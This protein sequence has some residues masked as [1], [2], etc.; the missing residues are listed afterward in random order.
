MRHHHFFLGL[1]VTLL[2]A[3]AGGVTVRVNAISDAQLHAAGKHYLLVHATAQANK[4]DLFFREFSSYFVKALQ[5]KGYQRVADVQ[6]ADM[7]IDFSYGVSEGRT[8]INTYSFPIYEATGGETIT[9][10]ETKTDSSGK[11]TT[12]RR[13]VT[14]PPRYQIVGTQLESSTYTLYTHNAVLEARLPAPQGQVGK[15]LWKTVITAVVD[16]N[17]LRAIMP[18]LA[19]AA[20]PYLG[21]NSGAQKSINLK[22]DSPAVVEM[23]GAGKP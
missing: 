2:T 19:A 21:G 5:A 7:V 1:I 3:C 13:T 16:T 8:G 15:L 22:A 11:V 4:D 18:Y 10:T 14:V 6:Q 20:V 12:T 17:D 9:F 23:R